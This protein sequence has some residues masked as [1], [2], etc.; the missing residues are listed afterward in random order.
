MA[1]GEQRG[2]ASPSKSEV[3]DPLSRLREDLRP[4]TAGEGSGTQSAQIT[5]LSTGDRGTQ[6]PALVH[7]NVVK[8]YMT[9]QDMD[10]R[11][12]EAVNKHFLNKYA[13]F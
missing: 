8:N 1:L 3:W 10:K 4:A 2:Y 6:R 5:G 11:V 9:A 12:P 7:S 13:K